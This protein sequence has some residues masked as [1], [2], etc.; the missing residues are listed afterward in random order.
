MDKNCPTELGVSM[1]DKLRLRVKYENLDIDNQ[2]LSPLYGWELKQTRINDE[3]PK[4]KHF[5]NL[6]KL[7]LEIC[8]YGLKIDFNPNKIIGIE[9][10]RGVLTYNQLQQSIEY[11]EEQLLEHGLKLKRL[12]KIALITSYH[13]SFDIIPNNGY[14]VYRPIL[15]SITTP[16]RLDRRIEKGTLYYQTSDNSKVITVYDK[17]KERNDNNKAP[18]LDYNCIRFENRYNKIRAKKR[19]LLSALSETEYYSRRAKQK[20]EIDRLLFNGNNSYHI[21]GSWVADYLIEQSNNFGL[22]MST[23]SDIGK[24][25]VSEVKT[26]YATNQLMN[27]TDAQKRSARRFIN[28]IQEMYVSSNEYCLELYNELKNLFKSVA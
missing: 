12:D 6:E 15:E 10:A 13:N 20:A 5:C 3:Q 26:P 4:D 18:A 8:G 9:P 11:V 22:G 23:F 25:C 17:T 1:N 14:D 2:N 19:I 27:G 7:V 24:R 21:F 28:A 16:N